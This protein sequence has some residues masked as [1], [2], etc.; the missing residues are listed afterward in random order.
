M[1]I[2]ISSLGRYNPWWKKSE[3]WESKDIS[4]RNLEEIIPRK[5][6]SLREGDIF[7]IRGIRRS[8]KS[9]YLRLLIKSLIECG[10]DPRK[11]LYISCDRYTLREIRNIVDEF[12]RRE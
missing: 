9:V 10:V 4:L 2:R 7:I 1:A 8:G 12:R 11:I 3:G 5:D 6:I